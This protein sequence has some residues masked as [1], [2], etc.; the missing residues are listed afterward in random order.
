MKHSKKICLKLQGPE[1]SYLVYII[2]YRS[3]TKVVQIMSLGSKL[4][5]PRGS[6]FNIDLYKEN[7]K[8][9]LLF[10][11]YWEFDQISQEKNLGCPLSKLFK[12]FQLV[13]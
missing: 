10:N 8:R 4:T 6:Q 1:L 2:I 3:S 7:F 13:A 11:H 9:H 12:L 5:P